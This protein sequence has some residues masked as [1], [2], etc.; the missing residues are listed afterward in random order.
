MP[1]VRMKTALA[2]RNLSVEYGELV[3]TSPER[4]AQ[5]IDAG[6]AEAVTSEAVRTPER[7]QRFETRRRVGRPRKN[8][9]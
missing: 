7:G 4:A 8:P 9:I 3:E 1:T 2:D 6:I 5:W